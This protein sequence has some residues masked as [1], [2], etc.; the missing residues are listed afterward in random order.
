MRRSPRRRQVLLMLASL[1][2]ATPTALAKACGIDATRLK[3]IMFGKWP[4]YSTDTA[5]IPMGLAVLD[6]TN[7][8]RKIYRITARRRKK[9]RQLTA[10]SVRKAVARRAAR[11]QAIGKQP[12]ANSLDEPASSSK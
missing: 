2:E 12:A 10:R 4:Y 8:R 1:T 6:E 5:P 11:E 3:W 7:A 9:A